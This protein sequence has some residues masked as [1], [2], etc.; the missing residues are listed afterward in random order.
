MLK[1]KFLVSQITSVAPQIINGLI[2]IKLRDKKYDILEVTDNSVKFYDNPWVLRW[3]SEQVRRLDE[4]VFTIDTTDNNTSVNLHYHLNLLQPLIGI[5]IPV[6]GTIII[7]AYYG[8]VFFISF[9]II[10]L[11]VQSIISRNVAKD[12]LIAIL[13]EDIMN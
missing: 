2:Q 7:G 11:C 3:R 8:T 4:G 13:N 10:A 12:M 5:S 1:M 9:I 6:I